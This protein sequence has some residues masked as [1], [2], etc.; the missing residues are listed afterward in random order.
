M[1]YLVAVLADRI[2]AEAAYSALE[3]EGLPTGYWCHFRKFI[4]SLLKAWYGQAGSAGNEHGYGWLPRI[5]ADH[6]QQATFA[7]MARGEA[8]RNVIVF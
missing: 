4:V 1:N 2:K 3:K 7:R 8:T 6:S 5:E